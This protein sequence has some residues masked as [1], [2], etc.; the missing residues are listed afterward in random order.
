MSEYTPG[1]WR[2]ADFAIDDSNFISQMICQL[3]SGR[4]IEE[5]A[6]NARLIVAAPELLFELKRGLV[7]LQCIEEETKYCTAV[8]QSFWKK[9]IAKAEGKNNENL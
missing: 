7:L 3:S 2:A 5:D 6:A 4:T 9:L 1:P 8:T